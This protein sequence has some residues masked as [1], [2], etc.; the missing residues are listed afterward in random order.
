VAE[1]AHGST[2][3]GGLVQEYPIRLCAARAKVGAPFRFAVG[4]EHCAR[5]YMI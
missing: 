4:A 2:P 5:F 3:A 1:T